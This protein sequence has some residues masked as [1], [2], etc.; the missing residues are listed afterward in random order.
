MESRYELK[1]DLIGTIPLMDKPPQGTGKQAWNGVCLA[2]V[3]SK[4]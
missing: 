4:K 3:V 2:L 1:A